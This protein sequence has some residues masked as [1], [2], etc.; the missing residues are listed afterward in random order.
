MFAN[1]VVKSES[2]NTLPSIMHNC[3]DVHIIF[4]H[5]KYGQGDRHIG[6]AVPQTNISF[7]QMLK[8]EHHNSTFLYCATT[9]SQMCVSV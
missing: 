3:T 4:T 7:W 2:K 1:C 5:Q 8:V 9:L 6:G